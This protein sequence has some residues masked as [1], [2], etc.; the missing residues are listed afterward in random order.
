M[1][2]KSLEVFNDNILNKAGALFG[3]KFNE[4]IKVGGF[5]NLIYGYSLNDRDYILRISHSLHRTIELVEAELDFIHY[6]WENN[7]NVS[8]P[9]LSVNGKF[10]EKIEAEDGSY[11]IATAFD[12]AKGER[13]K[14]DVLTDEFF[15]NYGRTIG[16]FHKLTKDY[17][18]GKSKRY[19]WDEDPILKNTKE[20]LPEEDGIIYEKLQSL[21][22]QINQIKQTNDNFGLIHTDIHMGNFFVSNNE[23][24]VFDFD[25][26]AYQY[27]ISD[28]AIVVYYYI[29]LIFDE[30][31]R[32][33]RAKKLLSLFMKGYNLENK[34]QEEDFLTIELFL[35]LRE[36]I[37][38]IVI[39]RSN[40]KDKWAKDYIEF[41][42][43]RIIDDIPFVDIDYKEFI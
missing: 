19:R 29:W 3:V 30:N 28:I 2:I 25:D 22:N 42:R 31:E 15:I 9:V 37:L 24:T 26:L 38:Y 39:F 40:V 14:R 10:V 35:K 23:L 18:A 11:F 4:L 20:Y 33:A 1:D 13:P 36:F 27:F 43:Q 12:K 5:E 7:A 16:K 8:M 21:I 41:Y 6:L 32:V 17:Q 34:L